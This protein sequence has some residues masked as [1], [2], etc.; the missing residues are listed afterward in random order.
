[1]NRPAAIATILLVAAMVLFTGCAY[2]KSEHPHQASWP[3]GSSGA[4]R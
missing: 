1:V 2:W 4:G 3:A